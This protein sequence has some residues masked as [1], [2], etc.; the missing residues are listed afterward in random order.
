MTSPGD[1]AL[2]ICATLTKYASG[3]RHL[4]TAARN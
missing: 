4:H 1:P 2:G 3:A